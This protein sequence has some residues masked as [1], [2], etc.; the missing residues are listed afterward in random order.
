MKP[1]RLATFLLSINGLMLLYYAYSWSSAVYL[2]FALLSLV[3]AYGVRRENRTAI[4]AALIY[5]G[6]SFFLALL[7]LIAGNLYSAVDTAVNFFILH[8]ILD[9]IKEAA[10]PEEGTERENG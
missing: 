4:K 3:L 5:S 9:Y 1:L 10:G 2:T 6:A 8:D 7:F